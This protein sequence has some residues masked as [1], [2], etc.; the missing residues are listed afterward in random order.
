MH[1]GINICLENL[2]EL[3]IATR[4]QSAMNLET[5]CPDRPMGR[6]QNR[7]DKDGGPDLVGNA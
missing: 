6:G 1:I 5:D 3:E 7:L 4:K 2:I